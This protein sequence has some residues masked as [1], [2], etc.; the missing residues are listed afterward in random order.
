MLL[1]LYALDV[2]GLLEKMV[3]I[4]PLITVK[5]VEISSLFYQELLDCESAHGGSEY[6]MLTYEGRLLLQLHCQD[7]H[8]HPG[9]WDSKIP[10][11]NGVIL[12]FRTNDFENCVSKV[13]KLGAEIVSEP[14]INPNAQQNEIWFRDPDG[15]LVVISD[16]IG[17]A[18][19]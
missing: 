2:Q 5:D 10:S 6:E 15:Y 17:N 16:N 8:E 19:T 12:W 18:R 14:H 3:N 1:S 9:M 4:E 7:A 11:G 13:R